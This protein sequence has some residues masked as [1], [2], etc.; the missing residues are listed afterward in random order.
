MSAWVYCVMRNEATILPYWLRH[1]S[2]FCDRMI[3]YDDQSDDGTADMAVKLGAEVRSYPF[4]GMDDS[5]FVALANEQ[6]KEARGQADWVIWVD[7]DEFLYH[8]RIA[9]RLKE[10]TELGV[11]LPTVHGYNMTGDH[12]PTGPGQ[13]YDEIQT[14]F[15]HD[16]YNKP[17]VVDPTLD[18]AWTVGKHSINVSGPFVSNR[19]DP[20]KLLHYRWLG[21]A[22]FLKRSAHH[23]ARMSATNKANR[24]CYEMAPGWTGEWGP[25]WYEQ[26]RQ[27]AE[28]CV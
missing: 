13:I 17:I 14:G 4:Y 27:H 2:M 22:Y 18:I 15:P 11:T 8:P 6:Y 9:R 25:D 7:A 1:Y 5:L 26:Q 23:W 10:L 12:P 24:F 3:I 19:D 21:R 16:R 20:F 28:V